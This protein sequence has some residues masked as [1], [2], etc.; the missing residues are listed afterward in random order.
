MGRWA[1]RE[2]ASTSRWELELKDTSL[3][4]ATTDAC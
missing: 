3:K 2:T 4:K 1:A